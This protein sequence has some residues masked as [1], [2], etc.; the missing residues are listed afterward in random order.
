MKVIPSARK[1]KSGYKPILKKG[2]ETEV[3]QQAQR[4]RYDKV[5]GEWVW[6]DKYAVGATYPSREEAI[7]A[8]DSVRQER[9]EFYKNKMENASSEKQ[10]K[11]YEG[12]A[13]EYEG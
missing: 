2:R 13:L 1:S 4:K 8:A 3:V 11:W 10:R 7:A 9:Y 6:S 5:L 12:I